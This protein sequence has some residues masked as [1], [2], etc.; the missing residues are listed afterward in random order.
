MQ[1]GAPFNA[2][3]GRAAAGHAS[4]KQLQERAQ[5]SDVGFAGRVSN[6]RDARRG[7]GC[8]KGCLGPGHRCF[9][10]IDR[11]GLQ[12]VGHFER[13]PSISHHPCAHRGECFEMGRDAS[14]RRKI[15]ARRGQPRA[16]AARQQRTEE[17]NG[18]SKAPDERGVGLVLHER[19]TAYAKR[20]RADAVDGRAQIDQQ[21]YHHLDVADARH[22][23]EDAL[24]GGQQTRSEERKRAVLVALDV[25]GSRE[26]VAAFNRKCGHKSVR[27]VRLQ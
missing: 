3:R 13:M 15:S 18:A 17:Q 1:A 10:Q 6:L 19:P 16:P 27:S 8:E 26:P 11:G 14:P 4:A 25:N 5:L 9:I 7:R 21:A 2:N 24:F 22:V 20:R 23:G 12:P